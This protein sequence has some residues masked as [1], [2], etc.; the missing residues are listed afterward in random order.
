MKGNFNVLPYAG[1]QIRFRHGSLTTLKTFQAE[2]TRILVHHQANDLIKAHTN[3]PYHLRRRRALLPPILSILKNYPLQGTGLFFSLLPGR[4]YLGL[5][6]I[7]HIF[8]QKIHQ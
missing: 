1:Y 4:P 8:K 5:K 2:K 6:H 3:I 7:A